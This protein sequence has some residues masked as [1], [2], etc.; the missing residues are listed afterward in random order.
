[1]IRVPL[2][3]NSVLISW[4]LG[5]MHMPARKQ[6]R[7]VRCLSMSPLLTLGL[8]QFSTRSSRLG[9]LLLLTICSFSV[10]G[11]DRGSPSWI[12]KEKLV[13]ACMLGDVDAVKETLR[14]GASPNSKDDFGNPAIMLAVRPSVYAGSAEPAEIVNLLLDAGADINAVNDFGSTA[15]FLTRK[16][17]PNIPIPTD[18]LHVLLRRG[19]NIK[20]KDRFGMTLEQYR[21]GDADKL[22]GIDDQIWRYL[23]DGNIRTDDY[24]PNAKRYSNGATF[25]MGA[26]YYAE[27]H[28]RPTMF[29]PDASTD[30]N[31]E[32]YLFYLAGREKY[33][34][35]EL[36]V[37]DPKIIDIRNADGETALIRGA[38]F[39]GDLFVFRLL[40]NNANPD[41]RDPS[42]LSALDHAVLTDSYMTVFNLLMKADASRTG[43]DGKTALIRAIENNAARSVNAF[44]VARLLADEVGKNRKKGKAQQSDLK[45]AE[46]FRR[47]NIDQGDKNGRTPL[48]HAVAAGNVAI[49][50]ELLNLKPKRTLRDQDGKTAADL[51]KSNPEIL[52]LLSGR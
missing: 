28:Q 46:S 37:F 30:N 50:K 34:A 23:F 11:Q 13:R 41:I 3:K 44:I 38:K 42:G 47:V 32:T 16:P 49:V 1:M 25:M 8:G 14:R 27:Y 20:A 31:G 29:R 19:A 26:A 22:M 5:R 48:M 7:Y 6:G 18:P 40:K 43:T 9:L 35:G 4:R 10:A 12:L 21:D 52:K 33:F 45:L 39:G 51:A 2:V 36:G 17:D 24:F 15:L